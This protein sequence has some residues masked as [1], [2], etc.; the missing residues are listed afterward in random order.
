MDLNN[1]AKLVFSPFPGF[2]KK[3]LLKKQTTNLVFS[4]RDAEFALRGAG[5][6]Q[7]ALEVAIWI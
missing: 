7:E 1:K 2:G 6:S 3:L 5:L 4:S